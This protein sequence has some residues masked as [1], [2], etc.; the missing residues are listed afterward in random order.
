[1]Q[2]GLIA[3]EVDSIYPE[4]VTHDAKGEIQGVRY[5]LLSPLLLKQVQ[6]QDHET[7]ELR[8][9]IASLR[10]AL[11]QRDAQVSALRDQ[12]DELTK[13]EAQIDRLERKVNALERAL[14]TADPKLH[15]ASAI[16]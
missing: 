9:E 4:L 11:D 16:H 6:K 12:I 10:G 13:S 15:L 2:Y 3:E 14:R 7:A 5:D 1:M 8:R